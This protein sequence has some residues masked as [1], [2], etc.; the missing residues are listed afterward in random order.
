MTSER[1]MASAWGGASVVNFLASTIEAVRVDIISGFRSRCSILAERCHYLIPLSRK[2]W[3][4]SVYRSLPSC[5]ERGENRLTGLSV[6]G[7]YGFYPLQS[8]MHIVD[9]SYTYN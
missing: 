3:I 8:F 1:Y 9:I 5:L 7:R 6:F 4:I 2:K